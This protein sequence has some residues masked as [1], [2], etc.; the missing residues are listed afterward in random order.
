MANVSKHEKKQ[1]LHIAFS[2]SATRVAAYDFFEITAAVSWRH[3]HGW[4]ESS[5]GTRRE[6]EQLCDAADGSLFRLMFI[7]PAPAATLLSTAR[8][9][10]PEFNWHFPR[11]GQ[12]AGIQFDFD[13]STLP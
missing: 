10:Q 4:S 12:I 3:C 7:V 13:R 1:P 9:C 11:A 6:V 5:D 8:S 2:Q